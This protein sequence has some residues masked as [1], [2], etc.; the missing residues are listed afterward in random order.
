MGNARKLLCVGLFVCVVLASMPFNMQTVKA[1]DLML[2][3]DVSHL[4]QGEGRAQYWVDAGGSVD[5]TVYAKL[6]T[7][8]FLNASLYCDAMKLEGWT[9]TWVSTPNAIVGK[10]NTVTLRL[11][12]P[13]TATNRTYDLLYYWYFQGVHWGNL[14]F[15]IHV[16]SSIPY[17]P[18]QPW[19]D[20]SGSHTYILAENVLRDCYVPC[21]PVL[22][23]IT[24][25]VPDDG[26]KYYFDAYF[27]PFLGGA[28]QDG[29]FFGLRGVFNF[30]FWGYKWGL[31][32]EGIDH[33]F[34]IDFNDE[35]DTL[36]E[37]LAIPMKFHC[38]GENGSELDT[39]VFNTTLYCDITGGTSNV[40]DFVPDG[41][42]DVCDVA[43][44]AKCFGQNVP[45]VPI[46][47]DLSG[48][49]VGVPD[50][51]IDVSDVALVAK[52]FG[53]HFP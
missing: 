17:V 23:T 34:V 42:V 39:L 32:F 8:G 37:E 27:D 18:Y 20:D 15:L 30:S 12:V 29:E 16:N 52:H 28:I 26:K 13:S 35:N 6:L 50:G 53:E 14:E 10:N 40:W 44:V 45:P 9:L 25:Y 4:F 7:A 24:F 1:D 38:A 2:S 46:N 36:L 21:D 49:T 43:I 31:G 33:N 5:I 48:A 41:K 22:F 51:K 3:Y 11:S 47:C 19:Y